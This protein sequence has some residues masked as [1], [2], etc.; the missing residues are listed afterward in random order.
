MSENNFVTNNDALKV[1][2]FISR[3]N[4]GPVPKLYGESLVAA[5]RLDER[6]FCLCADLVGATETDLFRDQL[7]ERF[8]HTGIA[9]ANM[10]GIAGGLARS[11]IIPFVHSFCVFVS[12][13]CYDQI[14]MQVAYPKLPIKIV[15]FLPGLTTLLGVSHQA[16]D[17]IALMRA[18]PNMTIIEPDGPEQLGLAVDAAL[19]I[20]G[21]VY[22]RLKRAAA[23]S[24][25]KLKKR[26]LRPGLA[27]ILR[28]GPDATIIACGMMVQEALYAA[29]LLS[30]EDI[31]VSVL[32]MATI[33][34]LDVKAVIDLARKT[35]VIVTAENHSI[36]GGL[37]SSVAETLMEESIVVK[38]A[39]VGIR[40]TFAEGGSTPYLFDQYRLS[41]KH[42]A[43]VVKGLL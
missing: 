2:D 21:P 36:I 11:G 9:E 20:E 43:H 8:V 12:R 16:I 27:E 35:K 31:Q 33:K 17:D 14:A 5:A 10:I 22:L 4:T 1:D 29:D 39:R 13:R 15:G 30:T 40:D 26:S 23:I 25:S 28:H 32:N 18:L 38:F 6:I 41:A 7:P 42:I 24:S 34:P 19:A 37:G 3:G